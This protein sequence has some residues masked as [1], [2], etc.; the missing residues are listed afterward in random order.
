MIHKKTNKKKVAMVIFKA[1]NNKNSLSAARAERKYKTPDGSAKS[2]LKTRCK[3][4]S[5]ETQ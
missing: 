2:T 5:E 1:F 4:D 3:R